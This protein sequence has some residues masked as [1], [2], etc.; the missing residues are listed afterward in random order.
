MPIKSAIVRD[1]S[2]LFFLT[3]QVSTLFETFT[4]SILEY[5]IAYKETR[6][7]E[8]KNISAEINEAEDIEDTKYRWLTNPKVFL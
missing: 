5:A 4:N 2:G 1:R 6:R 3:L 7:N 8:I